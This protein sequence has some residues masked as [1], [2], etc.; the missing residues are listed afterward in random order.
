MKIISKTKDY[1][2]Y[3]GY[4]IDTNLI[5]NRNIKTDPQ[6]ESYM[7]PPSFIK[8]P[9]IYTFRMDTGRYMYEL[10]VLGFCGKFYPVMKVI[11]DLTYNTKSKYYRSIYT[12]PD[13]YSIS[14]V[15]DTNV[16]ENIFIKHKGN[17]IKIFIREFINI[18]NIENKDIFIDRKEPYFLIKF[19]YNMLNNNT[20]EIKEGFLLKDI[21]FQDVLDCNQTHQEISMFLPLIN[22]TDNCIN[23]NDTIKRDYHG[24]D[25][26]SFKYD[27]PGDK[28]T[29]RKLNKK[30]KQLK[31]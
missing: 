8:A 20:V 21:H 16:I 18:K 1:Y 11:E 17:Y 6:W 30:K 15:Y 7:L 31:K 26:K 29:R 28:K 13:N 2:D 22:N 27:K 10:Y 5:Y 19:Y 4:G 23:S 12:T 25:N 24:F 9:S 3:C 14:F